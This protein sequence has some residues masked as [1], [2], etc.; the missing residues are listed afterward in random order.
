MNF[1]LRFLRKQTKPVNELPPFERGL[2][3]E[4]YA[5]RWLKKQG[6]KILDRN[7]RA[8]KNTEIDI[9]LKKGRCVI[10][11]EV[12]ARREGSPYDPLHGIDPKKKRNLQ[13]AS[14]DYLKRLKR[15]GID[16]EDL[17]IRY[18]AVAVAFK[19]DGTPCG[20]TH[21][22][23]YLEPSDENFRSSL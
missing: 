15:C 2:Y 9:V 20:I 3:Y 23:S 21:Y 16:P 18:D 5:C 10:F 22:L 11:V 14:E 8:K 1:P 17:E 12:K 19:G 4:Q 13:V 6:Y 7:F